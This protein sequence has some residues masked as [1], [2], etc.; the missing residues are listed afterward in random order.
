M[1]KVRR[2]REP[3]GRVRFL[4]EEE[5]AALLSACRRSGNPHLYHIVVLA[6][7]TGMRQGEILNLAWP[8]V[9]LKRGRL[10]LHKT[11]NGDRRGVLLA[12]YALELLR[13]CA[14][15]RRY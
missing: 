12:G 3:A 2:M 8:D 11:K 5:R 15:V 7:S 9:D 10:T 1:S 4:S 6:L 14:K 13:E